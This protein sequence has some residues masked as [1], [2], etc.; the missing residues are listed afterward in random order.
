MSSPKP[1]DDLANK[2]G[3]RRQRYVLSEHLTMLF[4]YCF[5]GYLSSLNLKHYFCIRYLGYYPA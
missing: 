5:V 3:F 2:R 4:D 1:A